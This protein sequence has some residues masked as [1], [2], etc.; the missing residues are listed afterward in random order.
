MTPRGTYRDLVAGLTVGVM[1]VPQAMS[2]ASIA[3][4]SVEH[5]LYAAAFGSIFYGLMGTSPHVIIGPT[6]VMSIIVAS[7]VPR[8]WHGASVE[9]L[10]PTWTLLTFAMAFIAGI[11]QVAMGA[12][13]LGFIVELISEP[14]IVGFTS[15][16]SFLI[17]GTQIPSLL[18]IPKCKPSD[19]YPDDKTANDEC[20][21]HEVV[22]SIIIHLKDA[23]FANSICV[24]DVHMHSPIF[25]AISEKAEKG[26]IYSWISGPPCTMLHLY[27]CHVEHHVYLRLRC[28]RWKDIRCAL[29]YKNGRQHYI[30]LAFSDVAVWRH[31]HC[32]RFYNVVFL[33]D[34]HRAPRIHGIIHYI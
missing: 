4:L 17:A 24:S 9:P 2:Y 16:A 26:R 33:Y 32:A 19:L 12:L 15:A 29:S 34:S 7:S 5:G 1:C 31:G 10:T 27:P 22:Y 30:R 3:G 14:V 6:A 18:G 21:I 20:Y 23:K 11:I 25:Q 13:R 8:R 28:R